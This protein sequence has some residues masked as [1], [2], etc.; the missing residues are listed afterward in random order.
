MSMMGELTFFI[1]LQIKQS[2]DEIFINQAK[3]TKEL[4]KRFD[5]EASNAFD[6]PMS[7]SLK[8]DKDEKGKDVD[9]KRYRDGMTDYQVITLLQ[10]MLMAANS[11]RNRNAEENEA[12]IT[13][14]LIAGFTGQLHGW[15]DFYLTPTDQ[16]NILNSIKT[17]PNDYKSLNLKVLPSKTSKEKFFPS[18]EISV[19]FASKFPDE[20]REKTQLQRFL[21]SLNYIADFYQDL[22]KDTKVLYQRLQ[23]NPQ[24]WTI[25]HTQAIRRI[26]L[27]AKTLP[28]LCLLLPEAFKIVETDAP[29]LGY[30]GKMTPPRESLQRSSKGLQTRPNRYNLRNIGS[31]SSQPNREAML[32]NFGNSGYNVHTNCPD[33]FQIEDEEQDLSPIKV[34]TFEMLKMSED[35][36]NADIESSSGKES[37]DD[38]LMTDNMSTK[39]TPQQVNTDLKLKQIGITSLTK[40]GLD[41]HVWATLRDDRHLS[42]DDSLLGM[43]KTSLCNGPMS[44]K[45]PKI[46]FQGI[47]NNNSSVPETMYTVETPSEISSSS[48]QNQNQN[49][50]NPSVHDFDYNIL[51]IEDFQIDHK[52]LNDEFYANYN[53]TNRAWYRTNFSK[54]QK[55]QYKEL[56]FQTLR[57]Y[58]THFPFFGWFY[59]YCLDND[60]EVPDYMNP[61]KQINV[62]KRI[63]HEWFIW[64]THEKQES[65][66]PPFN[67][68]AMKGDMNS[69]F[70]AAPLKHIVDT[71]TSNHLNSV[72][73]GEI[74]SLAEQFNY[75]NIILSTIGEQTTR[76]K[77][78]VYYV[79][80]HLG[81][82][83]V[84][85]KVSILYWQ[86][87]KW[88]I[89][90]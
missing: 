41:T 53:R 29:D 55:A 35:E 78:T 17:E 69:N 66:H 79:V 86:S 1:G 23:K 76:I 80:F 64:S 65:V 84:W 83:V 48:G 58:K 77:D 9:I 74:Q 49:N 50:Y 52:K 85:G 32:E 2:K 8:L 43:I 16:N 61:Q 89:D 87:L 15:W 70:L 57:A 72:T 75:T 30:G 68:F 67:K 42:F 24:P 14:Y 38:E 12:I 45:D 21:G 31:S 18:K 56:F 44:G 82:F 47:R 19:E 10:H 28:C 4:L 33:N 62:F 20:I 26:K 40:E 63:T 90:L 22:Y 37:D 39:S 25:V 36:Y 11:T 6:T 73:A 60:I 27:R 51:V 88:E 46:I 71:S 3:Y 54:E 7:S 34:V 5:M 81:L 59:S 13:R